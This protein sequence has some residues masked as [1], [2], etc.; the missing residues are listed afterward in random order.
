M[1]LSTGLCVGCA[2]VASQ[3][4]SILVA[5][6]VDMLHW[7]LWVNCSAGGA[8]FGLGTGVTPSIGITFGILSLFIV[9]LC[10]V[11]L[12]TRLANGFARSFDWDLFPLRSYAVFAV[13]G[14]WI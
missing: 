2:C 8:F 3:C 10:D 9:I 14:R 4:L 13:G 11:L 7:A 12:L 5:W 6:D 1:E